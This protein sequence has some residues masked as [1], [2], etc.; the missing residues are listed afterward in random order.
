MESTGELIE[1]AGGGRI[2]AESDSGRLNVV[3]RASRSRPRG[4]PWALRYGVALG[5]PQLKQQEAQKVINA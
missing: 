4:I 1:R 2:D 5:Q 3:T